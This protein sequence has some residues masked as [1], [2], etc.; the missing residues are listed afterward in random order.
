MLPRR[1]SLAVRRPLSF[2]CCVPERDGFGLLGPRLQLA[3]DVFF[4][5]VFRH[6]VVSMLTPRCC[7]G[8]LPQHRTQIFQTETVTLRCLVQDRHRAIRQDLEMQNVKSLFAVRI[9]EEM[10]RY[11]ASTL[12]ELCEGVLLLSACPC[13]ARFG[14]IVPAC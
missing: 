2:F 7:R 14:D 1:P 6:V 8:T 10:V 5:R 4:S 9:L 12:H 13:L 11:M 3:G